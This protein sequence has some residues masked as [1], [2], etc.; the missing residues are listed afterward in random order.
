MDQ[1]WSALRAVLVR[2]VTTTGSYHVPLL[3][4][5]VTSSGSFSLPYGT[6]HTPRYRL[7]IKSPT[8]SHLGDILWGFKYIGERRLT[9][10]S[11]DAGYAP[12][13]S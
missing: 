7:G 6:A 1:Y 8:A 10:A 13:G 11:S 12:R 9:R 5:R 3:V 4:A 2:C